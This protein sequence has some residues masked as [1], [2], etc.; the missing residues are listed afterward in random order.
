MGYTDLTQHGFRST[1]RDWAA[2]AVSIRPT[3]KSYRDPNKASKVGA[4]GK[5]SPVMVAPEPNKSTKLKTLSLQNT[6][7]MNRAPIHIRKQAK[8]RQNGLLKR[9]TLLIVGFLKERFIWAKKKT[10]T[11]DADHD[12]HTGKTIS[13]MKCCVLMFHVLSSKNAP[14]LKMTKNYQK[15]SSMATYQIMTRPFVFQ[16]DLNRR[17]LMFIRTWISYHPS[18]QNKGD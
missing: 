6:R 10:H 2:E 8:S 18:H 13:L 17:S 16:V 15:Q 11:T 14:D 5:K 3:S 1:F 7:A 4:A 9:F 12:K